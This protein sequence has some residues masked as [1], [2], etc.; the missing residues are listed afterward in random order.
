MLITY[1]T[2]SSS[3]FSFFHLRIHWAVVVHLHWEHVTLES[4]N[5]KWASTKFP[6]LQ[7]W[8]WPPPVDLLPRGIWP[9]WWPILAVRWPA[10]K[11]E[12]LINSIN[13]T[14]KSIL[15]SGLITNLCFSHMIAFAYPL[16]LT[17]YTCHCMS[18]WWWIRT[19]CT[20]L[21]LIPILDQ[22]LYTPRKTVRKVG[23]K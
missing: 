9:K 2:S 8:P 17:L 10:G 20:V 22:C 12:I 11:P 6:P 16:Q 19:P 4:A 1:H 18:F 14:K 15:N 23:K 13:E 3:S 5:K 21:M 7:Q